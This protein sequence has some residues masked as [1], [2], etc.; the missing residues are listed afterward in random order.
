MKVQQPALLQLS[1]PLEIMQYMKR[2]ARVTYDKDQLFKVQ[3]YRA[4]LGQQRGLDPNLTE[5][6]TARIEFLAVSSLSKSFVLELKHYVHILWI[7]TDLFCFS[8]SS[9]VFG[10]NMVH[11]QS[12]LVLL[13]FLLLLL[14][15]TAKLIFFSPPQVAVSFTQTEQMI[16]WLYWMS[17]K[18]LMTQVSR[19]FRKFFKCGRAFIDAKL[20]KTFFF[21]IQSSYEDVKVFPTIETLDEKQA[22]YLGGADTRLDER[23]ITRDER[24]VCYSSYLVWFSVCFFKCSHFNVKTLVG[25]H[26]RHC[27]YYRYYHCHSTPPYV[28]VFFIINDYGNEHLY[29]ISAPTDFC[30]RLHIRVASVFGQ[31]NA[32]DVVKV[33]VLS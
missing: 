33:D 16:T 23:S 13:G 29:R 31:P 6:E 27:Y 30:H 1:C 25:H 15:F 3:L 21:S 18:C 28:T 9:F 2:A 22:K 26:Q 32:R 17:V 8:S 10:F 4:C 12:F 14:R 19:I 11:P 20:F 7:G 5:Q 24:T